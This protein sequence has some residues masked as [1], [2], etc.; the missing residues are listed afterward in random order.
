MQADIYKENGFSIDDWQLLE[1]EQAVPTEPGRFLVSLERFVAAPEA[2]ASLREIAILVRAG[3]DVT[4][5]A[6]HLDQFT[7][8]A[9]EFAAFSDGRGYSSARLL[10]QRLC[11]HGELRAVGDVLLDQIPLMRRCGFDAF[12]V[13]HEPTR[14]ALE[15]GHLAEVPLYLQ[16][17]ARPDE[18]PAGARAWARSPVGL[19]R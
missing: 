3:D 14:R 4:V 5:L 11:Y 19:A 9:I 12:K 1:D 6:P 15:T 7:M 18:Q 16:P 8:V 13:V 17:A 10:R 2:F